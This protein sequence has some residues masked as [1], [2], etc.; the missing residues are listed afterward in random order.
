MDPTPAPE[1]PAYSVTQA[2]LR[3]VKA[4]RDLIKLLGEQLEPLEEKLV[5][6]LSGI[7]DPARAIEPG[8]LTAFLKPNLARPTPN[9]KKVVE[10]ELGPAVVLATET[11][12]KEAVKGK[13]SSYSLKIESLS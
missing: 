6:A 9:W 1:A 3:D 10:D 4:K 12:A 2:T 5:G 8:P 11:A 13:V 7:A